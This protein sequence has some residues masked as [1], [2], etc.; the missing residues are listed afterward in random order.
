MNTDVWLTAGI[1]TKDD[2]SQTGVSTLD[3]F[4]NNR[5]QG[6]EGSKPTKERVLIDGQRG[7]GLMFLSPQGPQGVYSYQVFVM[8]E[9]VIYSLN[10]FAGKLNVLEKNQN[11][12]NRILPSAK[13]S[14]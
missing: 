3:D 1:L 10:M 8:K 5:I 13:F 2:L 12:F 6:A 14:D 11:I 4:I 7:Y 9:G